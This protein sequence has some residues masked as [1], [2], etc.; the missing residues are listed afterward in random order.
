MEAAD[1]FL[2]LFYDDNIVR[3]WG[4]EPENERFRER[5]FAHWEEYQTTG[6][7]SIHHKFQADTDTPAQKKAGQDRRRL[8]ARP[9]LRARVRWH[10]HKA[11]TLEQRKDFA[12]NV[13]NR[14]EPFEADII[15]NL[16]A[17][18]ALY[19]RKGQQE[20]D[21]Y[22][23][24]VRYLVLEAALSRPAFIALVRTI[25]RHYGDRVQ[26]PAT[27]DLLMRDWKRGYQEMRQPPVNNM[28]PWLTPSQDERDVAREVLPYEV[29]VV[30]GL[31][32]QSVDGAMAAGLSLLRV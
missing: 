1:D 25:W 8:W 15:R 6:P 18:N 20:A 30:R 21:D 32:K 19:A 4:H 16:F 24:M 28:L 26:I 14:F 9:L 7:S 29:A 31:Y 17:L 22:V 5:V 11:Y 27:F 13:F 10:L 3:L 12:V 23:E 2:S